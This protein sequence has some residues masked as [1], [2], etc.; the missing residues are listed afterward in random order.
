MRH[1]IVQL[2]HAF[3]Q[4]KAG[5]AHL[6]HKGGGRKT[7]SRVFGSELVEPDHFMTTVS[8]YSAIWVLISSLDL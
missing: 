8:K 1:I 4:K 2:S 7:G 6:R 3:A 5:F